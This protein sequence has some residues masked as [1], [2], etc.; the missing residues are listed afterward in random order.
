MRSLL[1]CVTLCVALVV[2]MCYDS[3]ESNESY[4]DMFVNRYRANTFIKVPG[5]NNYQWQKRYK[6]PAER[7]SEICENHFHCR[8]LAYRYGPQTAYQKYFGGRKV[9]NGLRY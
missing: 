7:Q 9:N 6:S 4:E 5:H 3:E 2:T 1:R 8:M